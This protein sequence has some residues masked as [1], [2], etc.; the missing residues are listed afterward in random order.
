MLRLLFAIVVLATPALS[1][2]NSTPALSEDNSLTDKGADVNAQDGSVGTLFFTPFYA[3]DLGADVNAQDGPVSTQFQEAAR[4]VQYA[5]RIDKETIE[6]LAGAVAEAVAS[7]SAKT[8]YETIT[9]KNSLKI[10]TSPP[11]G[12]AWNLPGSIIDQTDTNSK[13]F[14]VDQI[15]VQQGFGTS[16]WKKIEQANTESPVS[17]WV[18]VP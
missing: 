13:Y 15:E 16:K 1:E 3:E 10:R 4:I 5:A 11:N 2:D 9:F 8:N 17:G 7:A 12:S 6:A 14:V 18:R